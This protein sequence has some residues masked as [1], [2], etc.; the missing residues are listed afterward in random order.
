MDCPACGV[1]V[2]FPP[3]AIAD[4]QLH[5]CLA[6]PC[7]ELFLRKDFPQRLGVTIVVIGFVVSCIAWYYYMLWLT[8]VSLFAVAAIDLLLYFAV[9][10]VLT[11]YRCGAMYRGLGGNVENHGPF[12]LET[13]EKFRQQAARIRT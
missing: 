5:Q 9:G 10:E 7:K 12:D 1:T 13:H 4:G 11:C 2:E 3:G 8:F 6:C